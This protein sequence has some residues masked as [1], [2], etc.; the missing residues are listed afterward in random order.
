MGCEYRENRGFVGVFQ[1]LFAVVFALTLAFAF[2]PLGAQTEAALVVKGRV[3]ERTTGLSVPGAYIINKR[4]ERGVL[5]EADGRF[6]IRASI[7][8]SLVVSHL[9]FKYYYKVV[10]AGD[11]RLV[12]RFALDE[13]NYLLD[14][15]G[16]NA[17]SLTTNDP[18]DVVFSEPLIPSNE[19]IEFPVHT[20]AGLG[21][22]VDFLY[23]RFGKTPRQM[24]ELRLLMERDAWRQKLQ[25]SNGQALQEL[26]GMNPAE[27][28]A[29][30]YYC[31]GGRIRHETDYELL[32]SLVDCYERYTRE[33]EI[34]EILE[35]YDRP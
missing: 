24:A 3:V 17:Y 15:A 26:T 8:D 20:P 9:S 12:H 7:G 14:E 6:E 2:F 1:R 32:R 5:S 18:R 11:E 35:E 28:Q 30:A 27:V 10:Q 25:G 22:P 29:F 19:Q 34:D 21:N 23:E 4:T 16:I 13:R 33:R 31:S